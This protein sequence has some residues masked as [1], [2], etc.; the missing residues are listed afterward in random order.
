MSDL[1]ILS[2]Y[3]F[4]IWK[5]AKI[6]HWIIFSED[7]SLI[8]LERCFSIHLDA[9]NLSQTEHMTSFY[10]LLLLFEG[11]F[12]QKI[13]VFAREIESEVLQDIHLQIP[14]ILVH[15]I[16][17]LHKILHRYF[18][19]MQHFGLLFIIFFP[20]LKIPDQLTCF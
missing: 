15:W 4:Y 11:N 8:Y 13:W 5:S 12:L 20:V 18:Q 16:F 9:N 1:Q 19:L 14:K 7:L 17:I 2:S 6:L 10:S 3:S